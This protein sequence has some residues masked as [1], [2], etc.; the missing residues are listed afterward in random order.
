MKFSTTPSGRTMKRLVSLQAALAVSVWS[1]AAS[2]QVATNSDAQRS[3]PWQTVTS[4]TAVSAMATQVFM[5][6]VFY[7]DPETTVGWKARFHV[8]VLAPT[9]TLTSLT[10]LNEYALKGEFGGKRPGCGD[11]AATPC[12]DSDPYG[13]LSSHSF[14][15]FSALGHGTAVFLVDTIKWSDGKLNAGSLMGDVV[16]PVILA[17]VTAVGRSAG[18]WEPTGSVVLSS[19]VGLAFGALTGM[20]YALLARPECG[21]TGDLICW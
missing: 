4:I 13:T 7:A 14:A 21:Y 8:S 17:V 5:P 18:N 3:V 6:R 12:T 1:W 10:L 9:L 15:A 11:S 16:V 19:G 20:T 2:A